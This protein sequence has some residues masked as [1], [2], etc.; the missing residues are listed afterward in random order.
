VRARGTLFTS[1]SPAV[2][3]K[4]LKAMRAQT[5][6]LNLRN[7]SHLS[8]EEFARIF[9]PT[10][11]G[12]IAYYGK[13]YPSAMWPIYRHADYTIRAWIMRKYRRLRRRK[14]RASLLLQRIA[15]QNPSLFA[16]WRFGGIGA[17]V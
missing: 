15:E 5:R 13:F 11:R 9:N 8:L 17:F 2:S 10:L 16:H 1:F 7:Q 3:A 4:S 12:W 6:R 14:V